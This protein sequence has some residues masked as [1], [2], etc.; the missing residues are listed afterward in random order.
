M[1]FYCI[2]TMSY[3]RTG[4]VESNGICALGLSVGVESHIDRNVFW[5]Q[6][7]SKEQWDLCCEVKWIPEVWTEEDSSSPRFITLQP[8]QIYKVPQ[9]T[10]LGSRYHKYTGCS[11]KLSL[12]LLLLATLHFGLYNIPGDSVYIP[13]FQITNI[14]VAPVNQILQ[15]LAYYTSAFTNIPGTSVYTSAF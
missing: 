4:T 8:L 7:R 15:V 14:Q 6:G 2:Y 1:P 3:G 11:S 10:L 13:G 9:Y 5:S 12:T